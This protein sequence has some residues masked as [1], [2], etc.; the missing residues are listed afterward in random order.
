MFITH[1]KFARA[2]TICLLLF[3]LLFSKHIYAHKIEHVVDIENGCEKKI[4][5]VNVKYGEIYIPN[6]AGKNFDSYAVNSYLSYM[7]IP[8]V[9]YVSWKDSQRKLHKEQISL[10]S[11]LTKRDMRIRNFEVRFNLCDDKL[12]V[13]Y[14]KPIPGEEFNMEKKEIW[15]EQ[16]YIGITPE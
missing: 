9:A 7:E 6:Q 5:E 10:T 14:Y 15:P 11:L 8:E 4:H 2:M 16:K 1:I 13:Y 12:N 3:F